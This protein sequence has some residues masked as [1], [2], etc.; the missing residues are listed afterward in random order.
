MQKDDRACRS[1]A[2]VSARLRLDD[3]SL[4]WEAF[5]F[6]VHPKSHSWQEHLS[7]HALFV[8]DQLLKELSLS[9]ALAS[10]RLD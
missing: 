2:R 6:L 10:R 8:K 5:G 3:V 7:N 4:V 1:A 9:E